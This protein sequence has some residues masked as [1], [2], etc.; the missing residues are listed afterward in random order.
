MRSSKSTFF[1]YNHIIAGRELNSHHKDQ[2]FHN[3]GNSMKSEHNKISLILI[4]AKKI[5]SDFL[6]SSVAHPNIISIFQ[7]KQSPTKII[8]VLLKEFK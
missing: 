4:P 2:I 7:R 6:A 5:A 1:I 3:I 8:E